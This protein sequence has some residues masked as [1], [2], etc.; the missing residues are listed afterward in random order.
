[1]SPYGPGQTPTT[2]FVVLPLVESRLAVEALLEPHAPRPAA[3]MMPAAVA[4]MS[5]L[6]V[7]HTVRTDIALSP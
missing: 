3:S 6:L 1:M 5:F 4:A 2:I 7:F